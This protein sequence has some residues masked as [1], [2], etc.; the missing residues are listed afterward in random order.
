MA[1]RV[2]VALEFPALVETRR[3]WPE[4]WV[5]QLELLW[6]F[7]EQTKHRHIG[8]L[9]PDVARTFLQIVRRASRCAKWPFV[10]E[11]SAQLFRD[12]RP[13]RERPSCVPFSTLLSLLPGWMRIKLHRARSSPSPP[14]PPPSCDLCVRRNCTRQNNANCITNRRS[15][16]AFYHRYLRNKR[17]LPPRICVI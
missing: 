5:R 9:T 10:F 3:R 15:N 7:A 11:I 8:H 13:R 1:T 2:A 16:I 4:G 6:Q 17:N 12:T 14:L